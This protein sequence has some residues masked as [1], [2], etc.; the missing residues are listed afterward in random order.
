MC[1]FLAPGIVCFFKRPSY[2]NIFSH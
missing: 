1:I 2:S